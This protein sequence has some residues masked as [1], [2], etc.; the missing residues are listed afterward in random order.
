MTNLVNE[1]WVGLVT[2][3]ILM[4][5]ARKVQG[6]QKYRNKSMGSSQFGIFIHLTVIDAGP[7]PAFLGLIF[8][9][10]SHATALSRC[11]SRSRPQCFLSRNT[12]SQCI[13]METGLLPSSSHELRNGAQEAEILERP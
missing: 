3:A 13:N 2:S 7:T 4:H 6:A 9:Q 11:K 12:K 8:C 10:L 5:S 1:L